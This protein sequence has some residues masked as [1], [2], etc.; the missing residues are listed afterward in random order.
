M[1]KTEH[2]DKKSELTLKW[3]EY[4]VKSLECKTEEDEGEFCTWFCLD[5]KHFI[6]RDCR[7]H[8]QELLRLNPIEKYR[9]LR[10]RSGHLIGLF[11]YTHLFH[12]LVNR[13]LGKPTMLYEDALIKYS[14]L[15]IDCSQVCFGTSGQKKSSD[16]KQRVGSST[17]STRSSVLTPHSPSNMFVERD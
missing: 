10:D 12:N 9:G 5:I 14:K 4:H 13:R 11:K 6:C 2:R 15:S 7:P 16:Q 17:S 1:S 8:A 3:T